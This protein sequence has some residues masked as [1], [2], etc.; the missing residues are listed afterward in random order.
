MNYSTEERKI[1]NKLRH[2]RQS[3]DRYKQEAEYYRKLSVL[4][5][6]ASFSFLITIICM[7]IWR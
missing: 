5:A 7:M 2:V 4:F 1:M 3:V 6:L